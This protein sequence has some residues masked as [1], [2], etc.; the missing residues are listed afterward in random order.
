MLKIAKDVYGSNENELEDFLRTK[1]SNLREL[2]HSFKGLLKVWAGTRKAT[3]D[4]VYIIYVISSGAC[5]FTKR[6][7]IKDRESFLYGVCCSFQSIEGLVESI[8]NNEEVH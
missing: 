8:G 2:N 6:K 7:G 5:F 1:H 4:G 3:G